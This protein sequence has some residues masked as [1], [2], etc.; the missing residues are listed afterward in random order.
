MAVLPS[1]R[2][3]LVEL[4]S[5]PPRPARAWTVATE[6]LLAAVG[7]GGPQEYRIAVADVEVTVWPALDCTG[8]FDAESLRDA[9]SEIASFDL[10]YVVV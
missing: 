1:H 9:L 3:D 5:E 10:R 6:Y 2:E 4:P 8:M 7:A